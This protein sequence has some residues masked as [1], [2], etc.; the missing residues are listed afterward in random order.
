[1]KKVLLAVAALSCLGSVALAGPNAGGTLIAGLS[2]GT[3]YTV[4]N[5]GYCGSSTT[6]DCA[7]TVNTVGGTDPAVINILAAFNGSPR[8][9]GVTFG[10]TYDV[11]L[12]E[13]GPCGD[14]E[15]PTGDWP[16]SGEG[17]AVTWST[18]QTDLLVEVYWFAAYDYYG[19]GGSINLGPH[20]TQ[21]G[22]FADDDVPSNIDP[23]A[24]YGIFG[25]SEPGFTPCPD[26]GP[27]PGACCFP[28][29]SCVVLFED[30]CTAGGGSFQGEG[31]T[32][33]PDPCPDPTGACCIDS[34]CVILT[35]AE[36][37]AQGGNYLG[38]GTNCDD[39]PCVVP[40]IESSWGS[41]KNI[42]R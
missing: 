26:A 14:F 5:T 11:N 28:D 18:A 20:P 13:A 1:M 38:D 7:A 21:G 25:F 36:C 30:E 29:G 27:R 10:V 40:T 19:T 35:A 15:L 9:A 39:D 8:L 4:D 41:L 12:L 17:T 23:I 34:T 33:D 32:C 3:V 2:V 16:S 37:G 42:Y 24:G 31:T 6:T 22:N